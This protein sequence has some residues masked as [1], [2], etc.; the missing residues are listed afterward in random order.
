MCRC[1]PRPQCDY[2]PHLNENFPPFFLLKQTNI[3]A[4][5][6]RLFS[7]QLGVGL[8]LSRQRYEKAMKKVQK[9]IFLP[10]QSRIHNS[11]GNRVEYTTVTEL[12]K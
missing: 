7:L 12:K 2:L 11:N 6:V 4:D 1:D 10:E 5:F 9:H 3:K 8:N